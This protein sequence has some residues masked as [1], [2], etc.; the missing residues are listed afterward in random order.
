MRSL[1]CRKVHGAALALALLAPAISACSRPARGPATPAPRPAP[2]LADDASAPG[3][4]EQECATVVAELRRYGQCG[5]LDDDRKW[6]LARWL[7]QVETDLAL[8][9]SPAV[10]EPA[11]Q[12]LA[13]SCR[14]AGLALTDAATRCAA[15]AAAR[16]K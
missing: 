16:G 14:K 11:K 15:Q 3:S 1:P 10:D 4:A 8:A 6:Y 5:L 2:I 9:R 13:V 12:Q 7:E